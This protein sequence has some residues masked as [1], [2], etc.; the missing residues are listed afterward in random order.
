ME[1]IGDECFRGSGIEERTLPGALRKADTGVFYECDNLK[2]IYVEDGCEA[3]LV[4]TRVPDS[5][6]VIPL[7]TALI[8]DVSI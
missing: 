2:T 4:G 3:S 7:S 1:R 8:G 5:I 6:S